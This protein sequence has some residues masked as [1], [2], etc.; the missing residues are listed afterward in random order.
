V[1]GHAQSLVLLPPKKGK[2]KNQKTN[3]QKTQALYAH[4]NNKR[5]K[6]GKNK[7]ICTALQKKKKDYT[8]CSV[9]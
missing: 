6:K 7:N 4:M 8:S 5:K 9:V 3:K 1:Q 2:K